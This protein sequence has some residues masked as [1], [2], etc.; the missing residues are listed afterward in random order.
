MKSVELP[1]QDYY[2]RT[3]QEFPAHLYDGRRFYPGK[4]HI[5][6]VGVCILLDMP[7]NAMKIQMSRITL[8]AEPELGCVREGGGCVIKG[9][10]A[11]EV[12]R[13]RR[14][15]RA[16]T[17]ELLLMATGPARVIQPRSLLSHR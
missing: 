16:E 6:S 15:Q 13:L 12:P 8:V 14:G 11:T 5:S 17:P 10:P 7:T 4:I 3:F 1:Y 2:L 9:R